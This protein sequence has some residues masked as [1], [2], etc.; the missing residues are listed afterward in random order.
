MKGLWEEL[1]QEKHDLLGPTSVQ[2]RSREEAIKW[3]VPFCD[4]VVRLISN[5][6]SNTVAAIFQVYSVQV[7]VV[8]VV[9]FLNEN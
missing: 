8:V 9:F 5:S 6:V 7:V 4:L 3:A 1:L 2:D